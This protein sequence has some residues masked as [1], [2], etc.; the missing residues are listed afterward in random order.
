MK[1][2]FPLF[3]L[4]LSLTFPVCLPSS[5]PLFPVSCNLFSFLSLSLPHS[6]LQPLLLSSFL[7]PSPPSYFSLYSILFS[8]SL[9]LPLTLSLLPPSPPS[10]PLLLS[11]SQSLQDFCHKFAFQHMTQVTLSEG[12]LELDGTLAK[13]FVQRAAEMGTFKT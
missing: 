5:L 13:Q 2:Y 11:F 7:P 6:P 4:T 8:L 9:P 1:P 10:L 12:F 3:C